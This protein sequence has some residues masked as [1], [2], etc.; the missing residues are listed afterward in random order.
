MQHRWR[1]LDGEDGVGRKVGARSLVSG[2]SGEALEDPL[3]TPPTAPTGESASEDCP[4]GFQ[5]QNIV[6]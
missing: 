2:I 4:R 5:Q 6:S 3:K 1:E